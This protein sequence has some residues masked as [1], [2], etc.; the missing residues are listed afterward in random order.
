MASEI[1]VGI[2]TMAFAE[3]AWHGYGSTVTAAPAPR[4]TSDARPGE[5]RTSDPPAGARSH[6]PRN[7][8]AGGNTPRPNDASRHSPQTN[9]RRSAGSGELVGSANI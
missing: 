5:S 1:V 4:Q 9:S 3:Q 8:C 7:P 2:D 6:P